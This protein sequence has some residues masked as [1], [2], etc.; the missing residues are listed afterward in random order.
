[1]QQLNKDFVQNQFNTEILTQTPNIVNPSDSF[2]HHPA[3]MPINIALSVTIPIVVFT[4]FAIALTLILSRSQCKPK[5]KRKA[6]LKYITLEDLRPVEVEIFLQDY[7]LEK[8]H[9]DY[10]RL[11]FPLNR[12]SRPVSRCNS[13][14]W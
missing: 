9:P 1:L 12:T 10:S 2:W 7:A 11:P 14:S 4:I 5:L 13:F 8:S 3:T 6:S